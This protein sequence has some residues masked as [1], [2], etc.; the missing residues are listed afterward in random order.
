VPNLL[1]RNRGNGTFV[2]EGV[3]SGAALSSDGRPQA[4]MGV[5][6]GD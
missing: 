1:Y 2:E 4:G 6:A 5:D 3:V